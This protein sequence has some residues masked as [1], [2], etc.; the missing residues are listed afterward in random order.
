[1]YTRKIRYQRS[2]RVIKQDNTVVKQYDSNKKKQDNQSI[3]WKIVRR[4]R[5][6]QKNRRSCD[7][8]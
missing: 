4:Q 1:M 7:K 3:K 8:T 2:C 5:G 6:K